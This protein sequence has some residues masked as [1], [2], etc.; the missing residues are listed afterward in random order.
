MGCLMGGS[1][2]QKKDN[3]RYNLVG[4]EMSCH[5]VG[6]DKLVGVSGGSNPWLHGGHIHKSRLLGWGTAL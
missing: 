2:R 4:L 5:N 6:W 3:L 1:L